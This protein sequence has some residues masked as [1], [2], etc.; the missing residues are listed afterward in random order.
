MDF[1]NENRNLQIANYL[2]TLRLEQNLTLEELSNLS[3]VPIVHLTSIEEGRFLR[4]DDF[5]L[6]MY[7]RRYT[8]SLGVDL[9]QLYIYASTQP[10]PDAENAK[11]K[12]NTAELQMTQ[13]QADISAIPKNLENAKPKR[14]KPTVKTASI[15]RLEAKRKIGKF[16]VGLSF[17]LLLLVIVFFIVTIIG[18]LG[19]REPAQTDY[20]PVVDNPHSIDPDPSDEPT[21]ADDTETEPEETEPEPEILTHIELDDHTGRTQIFTVVTELDEI[22]LRIEHADGNWIGGFF[23]GSSVINNTYHDTLNQT[24]TLTGNDTLNL[25]VGALHNITGI[26]INDEEVPFVVGDVGQQNLNFNVESE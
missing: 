25:N 3:Q 18:E 26:F 9:E 13:T 8:Q 11:S 19:N 4:F 1:S 14:K 23:N 2:Q 20:P 16:L 12:Q 5:Y 7:L 22:E 21:E 6:K 24:F 17:L 10:L 15:A